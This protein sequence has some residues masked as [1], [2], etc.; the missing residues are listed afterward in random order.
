MSKL[1]VEKAYT[2]SWS[3]K[4]VS[5]S[6]GLESSELTTSL[7]FCVGLNE[8]HAEAP[9]HAGQWHARAKR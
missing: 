2:K 9:D 1:A 6:L 3:K 5:L 7:A 4:L 8:S